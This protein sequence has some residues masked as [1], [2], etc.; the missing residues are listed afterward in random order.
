MLAFSS[1]TLTAPVLANWEK[2]LPSEISSATVSMLK[3]R[4]FQPAG[5][6][7]FEHTWAEVSTAS[8][9]PV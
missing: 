2:Q 4:F 9:M 8:G 3:K 7:F 1:T 6:Y 5:E